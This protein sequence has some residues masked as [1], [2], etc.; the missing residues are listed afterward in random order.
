MLSQTLQATRNPRAVLRHLLRIG[1][2]AIVSFPNFG[3]W[4]VRLQLAVA[5]PHA[6]APAL[7]P[8]PGTR[9]PTSISARSAISSRSAPTNGIRIERSVTL[10][11][12]GR[13]YR[14]NPVGALANLLAEQGLFLLAR[15]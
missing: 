1:Q 9:R 6:D 3:H 2:R 5:G 8:S 12:W 7:W 10:D 4:R 11:R 14:L 13:P 15:R